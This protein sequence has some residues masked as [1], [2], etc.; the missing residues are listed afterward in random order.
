[1]TIAQQ[2][3]N[4]AT[5][6]N[7]KAWQ[8]TTDKMVYAFYCLDYVSID[9]RGAETAVRKLEAAFEKLLLLAA[10]A[11]ITYIPAT[12]HHLIRGIINGNERRYYTR[13]REAAE[14]IARDINIRNKGA[15]ETS[16]KKGV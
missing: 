6:A 1:M 7:A 16:S 5:L 2:V 10:T 9:D 11:T 15:L 8:A 4:A 14:V 3:A 12:G 13:T